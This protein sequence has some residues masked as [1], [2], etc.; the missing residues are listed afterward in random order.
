MLKLSTITSTSHPKKKWKGSSSSQP[1]S[2]PANDRARSAARLKKN[3]GNWMILWAL[4]RKTNS[5]YS[6]TYQAGN[7]GNQKGLIRHKAVEVAISK[8]AGLLGSDRIH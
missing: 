1:V 5:D 4:K 6:F 7:C 3:A 2:I 8:G